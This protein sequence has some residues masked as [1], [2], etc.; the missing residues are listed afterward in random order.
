MTN[1]MIRRTSGAAAVALGLALLSA[2][3]A[4]AQTSGPRW[5]AWLGCWT[6]S[7]TGQNV[8][9]LKVAPVIC[10]SPTNSSDAAE[11]VTLSDTKVLSRDTIDASGAERIFT[12]KNCTT[13][14]TARWSAD[15]RRIYF[16]SASTC[17]GLKSTVSSIIASAPNGEWL[18]V[19][20][21]NAGDGSN[22]RVARY[23]P[24]PRSAMGDSLTSADERM[25]RAARVAAG[26]P[27][28]PTAIAEA[29][30]N[31][32]PKVVESWILEGDQRFS[33][34][35]KMLVTLAD[36]GIPGNVTDAMI[37]ASNPDA[38]QLARAD[39]IVTDD[40]VRGNRVYGGMMT[41]CDPYSRTYDSYDCRYSASRYGYGYG[42]NGY[43]Y[44]G[45]GSGYGYG[46]GYGTGYYYPPVVIISGPV[47]AVNAQAVKGQ[48]YTRNGSGSNGTAS[49]RDKSASSSSSSNTSSNT[50]PSSTSTSSSTD[51]TSSSNS[52]NSS[53]GRTA[54]GRP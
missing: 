24:V 17:D 18:E 25:T 6:P 20:G 7:G 48:G 28:G 33:L 13:S 19:R 10:V 16:K 43:G 3:P 5:Q 50:K 36:A 29:V 35:A 40:D 42:Y 22:V 52:T 54:H 49:Q 32:D 14:Q 27:I 37:A 45:Y 46:Y 1:T 15:E 38:F 2:S 23:R 30:K 53:S 12:T 9:D 47:A 31:V 21:V 4:S 11:L 41:N 8:L 26:A 34:D 51:N 39:R 44:N